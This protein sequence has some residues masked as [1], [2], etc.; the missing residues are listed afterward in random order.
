MAMML[1]GQ[2][3][4]AQTKVLRVVPQAC[5]VVEDSVTGVTAASAAGM[6]VLGFIGGGHA[7]SA[8]KDALRGVGARHI[9][10]DMSELPALVERWLGSGVL[11]VH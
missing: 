2:P 10:D 7:T 4:S 11:S 8:Q 3:I 1:A 5:L 9:F 6:T